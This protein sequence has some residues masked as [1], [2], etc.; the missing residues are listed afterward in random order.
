MEE[1][2]LIKCYPALEK[3]DEVIEIFN[4][5]VPGI[6]DVDITE[7]LAEVVYIPEFNGKSRNRGVFLK[8]N[9]N[10]VMNNRIEDC[11]SNKRKIYE[12]FQKYGYINILAYI[13]SVGVK[14]Q[15]DAPIAEHE[16]KL[17]TFSLPIRE[18]N[19]SVD[20]E[21]NDCDYY[22]GDKKCKEQEE[23]NGIKNIIS[24]SLGNVTYRGANPFV[25]I[26]SHRLEILWGKYS[27]IIELK[28]TK[29]HKNRFNHENNPY[30][31][32]YIAN[33]CLNRNKGK[34]KEEE[35]IEN[36]DSIYEHEIQQEINHS[37]NYIFDKVEQRLDLCLSKMD[38]WVWYFYILSKVCLL[39]NLNKLKTYEMLENDWRIQK[40]L[41]NIC[42]DKNPN[43]KDTKSYR[44]IS[45]MK[46]KRA[47]YFRS[48]FTYDCLVN[49][50][51]EKGRKMHII[52]KDYIA[53][54]IVTHVLYLFKGYVKHEDLLQ[55]LN[56]AM[57]TDEEI[58]NR[59]REKIKKLNSKIDNSKIDRLSIP[60][61]R[62][63]LQALY[64][65]IDKDKIMNKNTVTNW[66]KKYD[67]WVGNI[68]DIYIKGDIVSKANSEVS[69]CKIIEI[70]RM[71]DES[72][73]KK[74]K[75]RINRI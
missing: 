61:G 75:I 42:F 10:Y 62:M 15:L 23:T 27:R 1:N 29:E 65:C 31:W 6:K 19:I 56:A 51:Y 70:C 50:D 38:F 28:L 59:V 74:Y 8:E 3:K 11:D 57:G 69:N 63:L 46:T 30:F 67:N 9:Y 17:I 36:P 73:I 18:C 40:C 25:Y 43:G 71:L 7:D 41:N 32:P 47:E 24:A 39:D 55:V 54:L 26:K 45:K 14:Y 68:Y 33:V 44:A 4:T 16:I 52:Y 49:H 12:E 66:V 64:Y 58:R 13:W 37:Q 35:L 22:N 20:V 2:N 72:L 53:E 5:I 34:E 21:E 48:I 60:K